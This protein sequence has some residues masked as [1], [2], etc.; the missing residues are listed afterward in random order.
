MAHHN[1]INY[2][3]PTHYVLCEGGSAWYVF[4]PMPLYK[5]VV[6]AV[7]KYR[8]NHEPCVLSG[9]L[10]LIGIDA[11]LAVR[12]RP[13]FPIFITRDTPITPSGAAPCS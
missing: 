3:Q 6:E 12:A 11:I 9:D 7:G 10:N 8:I 5:A 4:G 2:L 13:D 1:H